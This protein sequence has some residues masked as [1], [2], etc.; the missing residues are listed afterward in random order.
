MPRKIKELSLYEQPLGS[1]YVKSTG[2]QPGTPTRDFIFCM[3][4]KKIRAE[5]VLWSPTDDETDELIKCARDIHYFAENYV[6]I[7]TLDEGLR[8]FKARDYQKE[9]YETV[10]NERFVIVLAPRQCG[11]TIAIVI[12]ILWHAMFNDHFNISIMANKGKNSTGILKRVKLAYENLPY[13]LKPG[14]KSWAQTSIEFDNGSTIS[15]GT[16]AEDSGRSESVNMLV[17]EEFAWVAPHIAKEFYTSAYPTIS[18][19]I[20]SKL[21]IV[22]T[23]NGVGNTYH[24]IY[25]KAKRK[26]NQYTPITVQW[27]SVPGRDEKFKQKT[28]ADI[29]QI[30]WNQEYECKFVGSITTLVDPGKLETILYEDP[31]SIETKWGGQYRYW[32]SP[33]KLRTYGI[34]V[35]I[36]L[37]VGEDHS[38]CN[39]FDITDPFDVQQVAVWDSNIVGTIDFPAVIEELGNYWNKANL[40]IENNNMGDGVIND[41][42]HDFEYDNIISYGQDRTRGIHSSR[43]TKTRACSHMKSMIEK[44]RVTLRDQKTIRELSS[45]SST[46]TG[47]FAG[48][49]SKDDHVTSMM[50]ALY[51]VNK[52]IIDK[53]EY[54]DESDQDQKGTELSTTLANKRTKAWYEDDEDDEDSNKGKSRREEDDQYDMPDFFSDKPKRISSSDK[55]VIPT[56]DVNRIKREDYNNMGYSQLFG[57]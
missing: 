44:G 31:I 33:E 53:I 35:D 20:T 7:I 3:K 45:Y 1:S 57:K 24:D 38:V 55:K 22:S 34:G 14:I 30:K 32:K 28:I 37:G 21:I 40:L 6:K 26:V 27:D 29:G 42:W 52:D 46:S 47:G 16:T 11:K 54:A 51:A 17:L 41:L 25:S 50:W 43:K 4:N 39:I 56:K 49:N 19:G 36:G 15:A 5:N 10:T 9:I 18:G 48:D 12:A 2:Y 23:P 8:K 13:W